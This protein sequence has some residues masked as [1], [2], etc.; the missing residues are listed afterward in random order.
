MV[1]ENIGKAI[2]S[3]HLLRI[4]P[5]TSKCHSTFL[6]YM[7]LTDYVQSQLSQASHGAIMRGLTTQIIK[8]LQIFLPPIEAQVEF[9]FV[10]RKME[11]M[12]EKQSQSTTEIHELLHSLAHKVFRGELGVDPSQDRMEHTAKLDSHSGNSF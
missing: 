10:V 2:I 1:P 11:S 8:E 3:Y 9:S 7:I 6:K 5:D 12:K 4:E